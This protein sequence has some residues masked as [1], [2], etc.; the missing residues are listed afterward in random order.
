MHSIKD[1]D[2]L[3]KNSFE[4]NPAL[5]FVYDQLQMASNLGRHYLLDLPFC[6]DEEA[7]RSEF[8]LLAQ[9]VALT[10]NDNNRTKL[11]HI[12]NNLHQINDIRPTLVALAD[13]V[14]L[15]DIQLFEIKKTAILTRKIADDLKAIRCD[16]FPLENMEAVVAILDP[17]HTNIPHFYVYSAYDHELA[18]LRERIEHAQST[19]EAE[20]YRFEAQKVE[21]RV[22][23]KLSQKLLTYHNAIAHNLDTLAHLDLL[24]AKARL[25]IQWNACRPNIGNHTRLMGLYNPEVDH[26]LREKGR[27]FQPVDIQFGREAILITGANMAGK[28]VLLKT[29][30]LAQHLFQ[31]G[32]YIP[33]KEADM[34]I[35]D[36]IIN[37]IGDNQS[38]TS[39]LS[40]FAVEILTVDKIIRSARA[41][42]KVLALVDELARTTNP[43][44][45]KI[46]VGNYL[47]LAQ[48]LGI[49]TL[50]TTH[51]SGIKATCRRLRVKGLQLSENQTITMG[52]IGDFMDYSLVETEADEVPMEAFTIA[53]LFGVDAEILGS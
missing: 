18:T 6:T 51:Y 39:G 50:V 14:T 41:G 53:K 43:E 11:T 24:L 4:Q 42:Q 31:F 27:T 1:Y 5:R 49:T 17:E 25:A 34:S 7:L 32:F 38:E 48:K 45:G 35:V 8:E 10:Q 47:H 16:V 3:F 22:R 15:D 33:A 36:I 37:S 30:S 44:E 29:V 21:D 20:E 46:L 2:M 26:A 19:A 28:S 52:N 23:G 12:R 40:S 13:G 9:T